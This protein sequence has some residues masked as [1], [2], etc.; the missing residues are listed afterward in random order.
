M[1]SKQPQQA[2]NAVIKSREYSEAEAGLKRAS[3]IAK[4][5]K[6]GQEWKSLQ[7]L[8]LGY[9]LSYWNCQNMQDLGNDSLLF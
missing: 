3:L 2:T 9:C 6:S 5:M 1:P 8:V 4:V 7:L